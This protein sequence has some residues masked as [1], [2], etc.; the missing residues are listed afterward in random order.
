MSLGSERAG[1][2]ITHHHVDKDRDEACND[3]LVPKNVPQSASASPSAPNSFSR[4]VKKGEYTSL[5]RAWRLGSPLHG[6]PPGQGVSDENRNRGMHDDA[7]NDLTAVLVDSAS[8]IFCLLPFSMENVMR[9]LQKSSLAG[10]YRAPED[11]ISSAPMYCSGLGLYYGD[12]H[13]RERV[14]LLG[15]QKGP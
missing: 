13:N 5:S 6:S 11:R 10:D 14:L 12:P 8:S 4:I 2:D 3:T 7:N 9:L 15:A 1:I